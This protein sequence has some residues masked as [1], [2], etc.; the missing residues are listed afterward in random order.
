MKIMADVQNSG[1][2]LWRK[3]LAEIL[4]ENSGGKFRRL[5]KFRRVSKI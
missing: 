4:A 5:I 2:K 1:G 3:I